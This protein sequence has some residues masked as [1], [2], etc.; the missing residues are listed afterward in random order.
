MELNLWVVIGFI[1]WVLFVVFVCKWLYAKGYL[2]Q[3]GSGS[4]WGSSD[5]FDG[6][7]GGDGDGGDGGDGD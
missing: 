6:D 4:E 2:V 3:R 5:G 7:D 1:V